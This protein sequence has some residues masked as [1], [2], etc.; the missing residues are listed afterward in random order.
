MIP[1]SSLR[2]GFWSALQIVVR[3][4][5]GGIYRVGVRGGWGTGEWATGINRKRQK[6]PRPYYALH[7]TRTNQRTVRNSITLTALPSSARLSTDVSR[8]SI[9]PS[10]CSQ[11]HILLPWHNNYAY[12]PHRHFLFIHCRAHFE[13]VIV[14]LFFFT[15]KSLL[16][17]KPNVSPGELTGSKNVSDK[18]CRE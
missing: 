1:W 13:Q 18:T 2:V 9:T 4:A 16:F 11:C 5:V 8:A 10:R 17:T 7:L 3:A 6:R 12:S 15:V 14:F